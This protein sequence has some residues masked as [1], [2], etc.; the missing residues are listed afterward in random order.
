MKSQNSKKKLQGYISSGKIGENFFPQKIQ[1]LCLK[2]YCDVNNY[3]L[4]LSATEFKMKKSNLVLKGLKEKIKSFD[5]VVFFS[6]KQ[7][8]KDKLSI[9]KYFVNCKKEIHFYYENLSIK[10]IKDFRKVVLLIKINNF[11]NKKK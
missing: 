10:S 5:G 7:I 8:D 11:I 3:T 1:N 6:I 4:I 2:N 9:L